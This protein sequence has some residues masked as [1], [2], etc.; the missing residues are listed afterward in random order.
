MAFSFSYLSANPITISSI[1]QTQET[2]NLGNGTLQ[3]NASGGAGQ[4]FYSVDGGTNF[5]ESNFFDGLESGDYLIIVTDG[6]ICT[7]VATA[8]I[9]DA[10]EPLLDIFF[11]CID[12]LNAANINLE[13]FDGIGPY[14][15]NWLGPNGTTYNTEDLNNVEPGD[16]FITVTDALGCQID[17]FIT[18]PTCCV[19]DIECSLQNTTA[20]SCVSDLSEIDISFQDQISLGDEDELLVN[21]RGVT[22][23]SACHSIIVEAF[24]SQNN[25]QSCANDAL[26]ITREYRITDGVYTTSCFEDFIIDN[27]AP[28]VIT[29][30]AQ[31]TSYACNQD[32]DARLQEWIDNIAFTQYEICSEPLSVITDPPSPQVNYSCAG[33]GSINVTFYLE[34]GCGNR[35]TTA[36]TFRVFDNIGPSIGCPPDLSIQIF[37]DSDLDQ[38]DAWLNDTSPFDACGPVTVTSDY[39]DIMLSDDCEASA[40]ITFTATDDCGNSNTC[41]ANINIENNINPLIT[42]PTPLTIECGGS[43]NTQIQDWLNSALGETSIGTILPVTSDFDQNQL[44]LLIC[45]ESLDV[46]FNVE[47]NCQRVNL[48]S[49]SIILEDTVEPTINCPANLQ[50]EAMAQNNLTLVESWVNQSS[51][52]DLCTDITLTSDFDATVLNDLCTTEEIVITF[53][54]VDECGNQNQCQGQIEVE[55]SPPTINCPQILMLDCEDP[56]LNEKI[57][58]WLDLAQA[59]DDQSRQ[60]NVVNNFVAT[61]LIL[62]CNELN[63]ITFQAEDD[64]NQTV[65]CATEIRINDSTPPNIS[66]PNDITLDLSEDDYQSEFVQ[67]Q[68]SVSGDDGCGN[69][70]ID[71]NDQLNIAFDDC[72]IIEA[73]QYTIIDGCNNS[74]SCI[75]NVTLINDFSISIVC[76]DDITVGCSQPQTPAT[77][78]NFLNLANVESD[79]SYLVFDNYDVNALNSGCVEEYDID[80]LFTAEDECGTLAECEAN[81]HL[82]P[83]M[84]IYIPNIFSPNS[85]DLNDSFTIFGNSSLERIISLTIYDRWGSKIHESLDF[86]ANDRSYGWKGTFNDSD[87]SGDVFTYLI[88]AED[89]FNK[90]HRFTGSIQAIK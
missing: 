12:T 79:L 9:A 16:Y 80:V 88:Y 84:K 48:C 20:L 55:K 5:Q 14:N 52:S 53:S 6:V 11:Q 26:I 67:W 70:V 56:S 82:L 54:A 59:S 77:I 71:Y 39:N 73:F 31:S 63:M 33:S 30:E 29:Q 22:V 34:D 18:V 7:E 89:I 43:N 78:S 69:F 86:P 58:D 15:F 75:S 37:Q 50:I 90:E 41:R 76:P 24:D 65:E 32:I 81:I 62:G 25:P 35:D 72:E 87:V 68:N 44:D 1:D 61:N 85:D 40:L 46:I 4:L 38:I 42:C 13:P 8:Q 10:P 45:G 21:A 17:S 2:C 49:T 60:L 19:L 57:N 3:I 28:I 66:C 64:C 36:A 47:D 51:A 23:L 83:E 74:A 27:Y